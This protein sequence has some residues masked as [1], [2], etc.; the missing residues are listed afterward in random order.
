MLDVD[1]N[2]ARLRKYIVENSRENAVLRHSKTQNVKRVQWSFLRES[3]SLE[4][5]FKTIFPNI[6]IEPSERKL[7]GKSGLIGYEATAMKDIGFGSECIPR[8]TKCYVG[9]MSSGKGVIDNKELTPVNF[10]LADGIKRKNNEIVQKVL[11]VFSTAKW[12]STT[13]KKEIIVPYLV[14]LVQMANREDTNIS[15]DIISKLSPEDMAKI[16]KDFGEILSAIRNTV[17][18]GEI[19]FPIGNEPLVDYVLYKDGD[20]KKYSVK[21]G[22]GGAAPSLQSIEK[23]LNEKAMG[24]KEIR[25]VLRLLGSR[26]HTCSDKVLHLSEYLLPE[27]FRFLKGICNEYPTQEA[28]NRVLLKK[29][30]ECKNA[31]YFYYWLEENVYKK[32]GKYSSFTSIQNYFDERTS[33]HHIFGCICSPLAYAINKKLN[34]IEPYQKI[35]NEVAHSLSVYQNYVSITKDRKDIKFETVAFA[36]MEF[37]YFTNPT[38]SNP[39][40][41]S[42]GFRA[43]KNKDTGRF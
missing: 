22:K 13:S 41:R 2:S 3:D 9:V 38:T 40:N 28:I 10:G 4:G 19:L 7:S 23:E 26:K 29:K 1:K 39:N 25:D 21:E 6:S 16:S 15:D 30:D 11:D 35:L 32:I 33:I 34:T 36:D 18:G 31:K 14:Y 8:G 43:I 5:E 12:N 17:D 37:E 24:K 27:F 42:I 20:V